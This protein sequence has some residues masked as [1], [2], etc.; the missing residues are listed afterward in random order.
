MTSIQPIILKLGGSLITEKSKPTPTLRHQL[1]QQ[2]AQELLQAYQI[3]P[4]WIFVHG[5][6]SFGHPL[7][8]KLGLQQGLRPNTDLK[9]LC[10]L[11]CLQHQ[12]STELCHIFLQHSLPCFPLQSSAL[13][14][15]HNQNILEFFTTPITKIQN[16]GLIPLLGGVPALDEQRKIS[17]LS[18]DQ[19][20]Y[21]LAQKLNPP[22][23]IHATQVG[24]VFTANPQTNKN[25]KR[26]PLIHQQNW[27]QIQPLL[28][29]PQYS[30]VSGGMQGKILQCLKI[31]QLNIPVAILNLQKPN[32]LLQLLQGKSWQGTLIL[33]PF[34]SPSNTLPIQIP[35][36]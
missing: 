27:P 19:I 24:G 3:Y 20:T 33:P 11:Q 5:A 31:A 6:G 21:A 30:D 23:V 36:P 16:L 14:L 15:L 18:G 34:A 17:I 1:L 13:F 25:A 29:S 4:H 32:N 26:I 9:E 2:I 7:A 28:N 22:L 35:Q 10:K 8:K 12:L